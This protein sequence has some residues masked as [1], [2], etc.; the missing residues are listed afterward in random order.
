MKVF[1]VIFAAATSMVGYHM[2]NSI[3]WA[4][5]DWILWPFAWVKWLLFHEVTLNIIKETFSFFLG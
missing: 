4:I 2:H 1:Y 5:V 3:L